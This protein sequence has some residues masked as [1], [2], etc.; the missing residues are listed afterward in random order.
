[1]DTQITT[2]R[3]AFPQGKQYAIP[4]YQ[5]NYVWTRQGQWEPL[6][7]DVKTLT[8]QALDAG[9][10][11]RPH[12]LGTIITKEIGTEGFITRWWVVDG[13]QR[14]TTLQI[15]IAAA[16]A[17]FSERGLVQYAD[18]LS[19]LLANGSMILKR[20]SDKYKIEH[21]S[22][23]YAG[24]AMIVEAA[25]S[26]S[27]G[28]VGQ[29]HL[30][31]CYAYFRKKVGEW[32][33][34]CGNDEI[35]RRAEAL[36][37]TT[38]THLQVVDI[39]LDGE[40]N[41]HAIF[42]ALN[43]RGEPLTEWEK[44]KNYILSLAVGKED[45]DGDHTYQDYLERYDEDPY[46]NEIV[47]VPRFTGKRIDLFLFFFA[48]IELPRRRQEMSGERDINTLQRNRLYR[49]FRFVGEHL[50]RRDR[51]ELLAMLERL[52][53]YA[54]IYRKITER[55]DFSEYAQEVLR[56]RGVLNLAS[57]IPVFMEL[58]A[59]LGYGKDL[60]RALRIVD[61]YLMRRIAL[62]ANYS[63]FDDVAF[64][65]VQALR[66]A[67]A[68]DICAVLIEQFLKSTGAHR[69]PSDEELALHLLT[70]DM[71]HGI[72][73]ARLRLLL[74]GIAARMHG[75][76]ERELVMPFALRRS[77]TV[78]HVAPQSWERHWQEDLEFGH[79]DEEKSRLDQLV[80]R[81]GNLTLV[82]TAI[83]PKLG[84]R[85]WDYKV[86]LLKKDNLEMNRRLR[87]DMVHS[88]WNEA[89]INRRSKQLADYITKIW[90]HA[91]ILREELGIAPPNG[92][93][94][95][96][97]SG[98]A[99][100]TARH[101]VDAVTNT[102]TDEGW[103][104]TKGLNRTKRGDRYGRYLRIGGGGRWQTAWFGVST[105]DRC[106]ALDYGGSEETETHLIPLP[107]ANF[108]EQLD[109]LTER[110]RELAHSISPEVDAI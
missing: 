28:A 96:L 8:D 48:Q 74:G 83:N 50:Y 66:D 40:E 104:D 38:L 22:S 92:N 44:T 60:D 75:E 86:K 3:L 27:N 2:V 56:K 110:V 53:S 46:W 102:G 65:H 45:P 78:E 1:M 26:P 36:T 55:E 58:V 80:H 43:A 17:A 15:L 73:S 52:K 70:R 54:D 7:E 62:K 101:L 79:T 103:V 64:A 82:T 109:D 85:P 41:G 20:P 6:W 77:L 100:K 71:Y 16:R 91:R 105:M 57:L 14:L 18:I 13:Q 33:D 10:K 24:F 68:D 9:S 31:P 87:K 19:E 5:R 34:L 63:G 51:L 49:E 42:E 39:R 99:P 90:P 30:T 32:L 89:E 108:Y 93:G 106:L 67:P 61:S 98:I 4:S 97:V 84:N 12:F 69:W 21:K 81:I 11:A 107:D 72:S 59:T 76:R 47:R 94:R 29:S 23:D 88:I 25:L 95:R 37:A 35:V